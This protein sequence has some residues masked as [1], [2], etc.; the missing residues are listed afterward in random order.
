[1]DT[2]ILYKGL[3]GETL[4]RGTSQFQ[5]HQPELMQKRN[6]LFHPC[7]FLISTLL[8]YFPQMTP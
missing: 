4:E 2:L 3:L 5:K 8:I 6:L 7:A 1:M